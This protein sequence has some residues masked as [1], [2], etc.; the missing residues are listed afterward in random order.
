[1]HAGNGRRVVR[2]IGQ[3]GL[4]VREG[5]LHDQRERAAGVRHG[6]PVHGTEHP[7][8]GLSRAPALPQDVLVLI[9][10][11]CL[12]VA[13]LVGVADR[14]PASRVRRHEARHVDVGDVPAAPKQEI[15]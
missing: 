6:D 11:L 5:L 3:R 10:V 1:M 9:A 8:R 14:D 12:G 4:L 13:V 7:A 2:S 15:Q